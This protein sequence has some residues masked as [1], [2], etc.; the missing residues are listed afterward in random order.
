MTVGIQLFIYLC[1]KKNFRANCSNGGKYETK[2][3]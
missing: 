1:Y 2:E 3:K